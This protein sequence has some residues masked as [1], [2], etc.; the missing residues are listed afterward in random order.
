MLSVVADC[1]SYSLEKNLKQRGKKD[2]ATKL[3]SS[4]DEVKAIDAN[5]ASC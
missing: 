5:I 3:K 2:T 4:V 1:S